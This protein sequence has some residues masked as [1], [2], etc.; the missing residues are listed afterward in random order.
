MNVRSAGN[1]I[2][3]EQVGSLVVVEERKYDNGESKLKL[4][5]R[6]AFGAGI[7]EPR[8]WQAGAEV[9]YQASK[10]QSNRF[11]VSSNVGFENA[12]K[13]S[14]GGYY[15]PNY[16]SFSSYLSRVVYRAGARY[17]NTG[18]VISSQSIYDAAGTFGLGFPITGTFSNINFGFEYGKRGTK[19]YGLV[20]ENYFNVSVGLSFNDR[21]F[22]KRRYD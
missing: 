13:Y 22:V 15:I 16:N 9:T 2:A 20:E 18:L 12:I 19:A 5:A 4:P 17:E 21:W 7:G 1:L 10:D 3:P 14:I 8:K 6:V 11:D